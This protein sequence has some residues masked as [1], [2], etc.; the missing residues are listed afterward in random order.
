[1]DILLHDLRLAFRSLRRTPGFALA[2][3]VSLGLGIGANTA[4]YTVYRSALLKPLPVTEPERLVNVQTQRADNVNA[5]LSYAHFE[6]L[7]AAGVFADVMAEA[8]GPL[9]IRF[10]NNTEQLQ[11]A[12]VTPNFFAVLGVQPLA[13]RTFGAEQEL[14]G[15]AP[16]VILL[17]ETLR[18]RWFGERFD[19]LGEAVHVNGQAFT[20]IGIMAAS[21][22][23]MIRGVRDEFW[24]PLASFPLV[25][26]TDFLTRPRVSWLNVVGRL[27]PGA[28]LASTRARLAALDARLR[29]DQLLEEAHHN[30]IVP[31]GHGFDWPVAE[32]RMPLR[33]LMTAVGVVLLIAC[34]NVANLLLARSAGR[35]R[36]MAVR[37]ALGGTRRRLL[38]Q[39][40][41][42]SLLL[43][44]LAG[45]SGLL[46]ASWLTDALAAYR[47]ADGTALLLDTRPDARIL[48]FTLG[49]SVLSGLLFGIGPALRAAPPD[50]M[51]QLRDS[52]RV[53]ARRGIRGA[54]VIAQVAL[55]LTLVGGALL[56]A[57]SLS[58]LTRVDLGFQARTALL[59]SFDLNAVA[60]DAER[61]QLLVQQL[62]QRVRALPGV[63]AATAAMTINPAPGGMRY[64]GVI[65]E[66]ASA[67]ANEAD[68]DVNV[69]DEQY[70]N[71]MGIEIVRGR[72]FNTGDRTGSPHVVIINEEMARRFWPDQDPIGRHLVV[73][74]ERA[75]KWQIIGVARD[76]KYRGLREGPTS[77]LWRP[78]R[79]MQR[80]YLKLIV[81]TRGKPLA[82]TEPVRNQLRALDPG[83]PLFDV[84]TLDQHIALAASQERMA[85]RLTTAFA[86]LALLLSAVGLYGLLAFTVVQQTREI[87]VRMA[88]GARR[89]VVLR[90]VL[91]RGLRLVGLGV[92]IGLPVALAA[93]RLLGSMLYGV[94]ATDPGS[95]A[96]GAVVLFLAGSL[97][98]LL[99]A[100][101][102]TRVD[103]M[104]AL[105]AE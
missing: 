59:A 39:L 58:H 94:E 15:A 85:M 83:L 44:L 47:S 87:G 33:Y 78:L 99:P 16:Q 40:L 75:I 54:L 56:L 103:P 86:L 9:A 97:A 55:S 8:T 50:L 95:F 72:S 81:R 76:G 67:P 105:R 28:T 1:M 35:R 7:R 63:I 91:G 32:L 46:L 43:A 90:D 62:L 88:L 36:D 64:G 104:T 49:I 23:G 11:G 2:A 37:L 53:S 4:I 84:R 20:V 41:T 57:R 17:S 80:S 3:I 60:Y 71:T 5:N 66:G 79:Q 12:A 30:L 65:I 68:F 101:R 24:I 10:G 19:V 61:G 98:T 13:G 26:G 18:S 96:L 27:Q 102:A 74:E 82:F 92:L 34:A 77:N 69:V 21:F 25:T 29:Q 31:A 93:S 42:E 73:D 51:P 52:T 38:R 70:F 22:T 45:A 6:A 14:G 48:L 89:S 100:R